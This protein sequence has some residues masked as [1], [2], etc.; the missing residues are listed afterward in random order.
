MTLKIR[1]TGELEEHTGRGPSL[2]TSEKVR[3]LQQPPAL[4]A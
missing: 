4:Q 3:S 2:V 1:H